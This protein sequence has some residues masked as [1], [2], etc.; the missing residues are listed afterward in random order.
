[1]RSAPRAA[2]SRRAR[3]PQ[4]RGDLGLLAGGDARVPG[5]EQSLRDEHVAGGVAV[6]ARR[7]GNPACR[8]GDYE[9]GCRHR[10]RFKALGGG[11][12]GGRAAQSPAD[13]DEPMQKRFDATAGFDRRRAASF[14]PAPALALLA[15]VVAL[16]WFPARPRHMDRSPRPRPATWRG[17]ATLRQGSMRRSWTATCGCGCACRRP[18]R[19]WCWTTAAPPTCASRAGSVR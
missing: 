9:D 2:G 8:Q 13:R 6:G 5:Q 16:S 15:A 10:H 12:T 3:L 17:S 4:Q 7:R 11:A 18:R 1:M 14:A 19:S